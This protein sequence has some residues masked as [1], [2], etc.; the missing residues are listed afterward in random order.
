MTWYAKQVLPVADRRT[1]LEF[2]NT[3]E[4][5]FKCGLMRY[6]RLRRGAMLEPCLSRSGL[7][8]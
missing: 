7:T 4:S 6:R 8:M 1:L 5:S 2:A 3:K